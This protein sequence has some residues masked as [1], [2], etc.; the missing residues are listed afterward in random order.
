[1]GF[2]EAAAY[3]EALGI[4]AMTSM[5]PSLRRI[6]A[7][8]EALDHPER[9]IPAIHITG[10]N[11][12]T[13]TARVAT[14]LLAAAG[15]SVGTYT[16]PHLNSIRE[17]IALSGEPISEDAF[18]ETF[19]HILPYLDMVETDLGEQLTYFEILTA[20]FFLWAAETPVDAMVVEV[21]LGGRYDATNVCVAPVAVITNVGLDHV[22]LLG[23]TRET[24]AREKAGIAKPGTVVA[25]TGERTPSVLEVIRREAR[26]AG[27]GLAVLGRDLEITDDQLA[28]GGRYVSLRTS[29]GDYDGLFLGL[30]GSH[31]AVNAAL[32]LEAVLRYLP[33]RRLEQEVV[34]E[35]FAAATAPGRLETVV[36]EDDD[37]PTVVFD[38]AHNPDGA[39]ALVRSL[40]EAFAFERVVFVL[41][42][43]GDKDYR[44]MLAELG[45][46]PCRIV[47]TEPRSVRSVPAD[48][49][50]AAAAE[51]G[52]A[53]AVVPDV[54]TAAEEA[55]RGAAA[56]EL[57]C[58]T[59]SHYVVGEAREHLVVAP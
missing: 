16:S 34:A 45:G 25:V 36:P 14:S 17:R 18:G 55:I 43:L 5:R 40:A 8:C 27:A 3:L 42:V 20:M 48:Q 23:E 24:I 44:G 22:A 1:M 39:A 15:L 2:A 12:K 4:D 31:Q 50:A 7:L 30:H 13:S 32:A 35:A 59:G 49:L 26:A 51:L 33:A 28:L 29:A 41:G 46:I 9:S 56:G 21:G 37:G 38:V 57:V 53:H 19:D 52:I 54:T 47:A 11:G 6:E 10:T 58:V